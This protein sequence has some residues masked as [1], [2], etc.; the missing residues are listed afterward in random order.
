[1]GAIT[2]AVGGI[3]NK[4]PGHRAQDKQLSSTSYAPTPS[5]TGAHAQAHY[6][7]HAAGLIQRPRER[8]YADNQN[9]D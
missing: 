6:N 4:Q 1:M 3:K 9:K 2:T 7:T 5:L 8:H